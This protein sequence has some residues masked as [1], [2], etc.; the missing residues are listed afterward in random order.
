[1]AV[2]RRSQLGGSRAP[3]TWHC[4]CTGAPSPTVLGEGLSPGWKVR[5]CSRDTGRAEPGHRGKAKGKTGRWRSR[6][7]TSGSQRALSTPSVDR[8]Q[9]RVGHAPERFLKLRQGVVGRKGTQRL[10]PEP[11]RHH[12]GGGRRVEKGA[13]GREPRVGRTGQRMG[14]WPWQGGGHVGAQGA[15]QGSLR[16]RRHSTEALQPGSWGQSRDCLLRDL[17][18]VTFPSSTFL[19]S[20]K[21]DNHRTHSL[22]MIV[23]R[24]R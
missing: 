16:E 12:P 18:H 10:M 7:T 5:I 14:D 3:T 1:M 23:R 20:T 6:I 8:G 21:P 2:S 13:A 15:R 17:G 19:T 9:H 24:S 11:G 4:G 22:L